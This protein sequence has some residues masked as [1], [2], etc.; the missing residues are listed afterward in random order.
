MSTESVACYN[1]NRDQHAPCGVV[2]PAESVVCHYCNK[3]EHYKR[4]CPGLTKI[5]GKHCRT[6]KHSE[7]KARS[8]GGAE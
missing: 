3:Q 1:C 2:T 7:G 6:K 8:G 5:Q 4:S